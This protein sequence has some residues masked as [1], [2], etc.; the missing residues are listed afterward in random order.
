MALT[1]QI[2][3]VKI[4]DKSGTTLSAYVINY[5]LVGQNCTLYWMLSDD[6][7]N[8]LY[9]GNYNVPQDVLI[10]WGTNDMSIMD[11]L[12]SSMG[13]V[14]VPPVVDISPIIDN[15]TS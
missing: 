6:L 11:S 8:K 13:F 2:Q 5:D 10:N 7:G 4:I 14:I 15:P 12:A 1:V 3:P 9:D